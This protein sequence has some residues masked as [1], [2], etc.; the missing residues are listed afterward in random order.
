[1]KKN[2][3]FLLIALVVFIGGATLLYNYLAP[4]TVTDV[5]PS[6]T[7]EK[8]LA[9]DFIVYDGEGN[10]VKFSD[11]AGTPVV[12]NFWASWCPPCKAEMPYFQS[13]FDTY[14]EDVKFLFVNSTDGSRET[15]EI[16]KAFLDKNNYTMDMYYD[17]D[18]SASNAYGIRSLPTTLF[19]D[20]D[21]YVNSYKIGSILK[22]DL[23]AGIKNI[24]E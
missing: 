5:A 12:I 1:M 18:F 11:F 20:K 23:I 15:V 17:L 4:D 16:A 13:A 14:K 24:I 3:I 2:T 19:I 21:G 22:K 10:K 6:T 8:I 9:P 7:E